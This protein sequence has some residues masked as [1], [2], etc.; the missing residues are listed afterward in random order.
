M[1]RSIRILVL[2]LLASVVST[3][4]VGCAPAMTMPAVAFEPRVYPYVP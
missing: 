3:L 1:S 4:A 2:A